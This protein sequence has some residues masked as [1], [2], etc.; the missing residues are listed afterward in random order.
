VSE[1]ETM[2][3][4]SAGDGEWTADWDEVL[5]RAAG[6]RSHARRVA[7]VT[8]AAAAGLVL[9]LP[10][11]GVGG[12]LK[13]LI[14]GSSRPGLV[15]RAALTLPGGQKIGSVSFQTSRIFIVVPRSPG[16]VGRRPK[17][18]VPVAWSQM[19]WILELTGT[20]TASSA[21]LLG[22]D[23]RRVALLCAPCGHGASGTLTVDRTKFAALFGRSGRV[24]VKTPAGV[25]RGTVRLTRGSR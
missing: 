5:R 7:A 16:T 6:P 4:G 11:I 19:R 24:V 15:L 21:L 12:R 13:E 2:I 17:P 1:L 20:E 22:P 25:A 23:G 3:R 14:A 18:V 9:L 8:I 10:G